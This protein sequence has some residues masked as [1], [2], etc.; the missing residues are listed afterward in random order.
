MKKNMLINSGVPGPENM[1]MKL[2]LAAHF[3]NIVMYTYRNVFSH[4]LNKNQF[5]PSGALFSNICCIVLG[6]FPKPSFV[7]HESNVV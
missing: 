6:E 1:L 2:V 3:F 4:E 5:K 7:W